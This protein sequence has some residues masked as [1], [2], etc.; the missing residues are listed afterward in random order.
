MSLHHSTVIV[1]DE[2]E[3]GQ[4]LMVRSPD[5]QQITYAVVP[6]GSRPGDSF[7]VQFPEYNPDDIV[8]DAEAATSAGCMPD[9]ERLLVPQPE[10]VEVTAVYDENPRGVDP[11]EGREGHD[12]HA[13]KADERE[14]TAEE[15]SFGN[16][17]DKFMEAVDDETAF[18]D[19]KAKESVGTTAAAPSRSTDLTTSGIQKKDTRE[20]EL[21]EQKFLL[22]HVPPGLPTGAM[23]QVE[24]PGENR[25]I[26]A[27]VPEGAR[28]F[29]MCYTPH[30]YVQAD[31]KITH[32]SPSTPPSSPSP[33]TPPSS[34][35][36]P[37]QP[38][39][40]ALMKKRSDGGPNVVNEVGKQKLLLVR[41]PP[42]TI[43]GTTVHVSVPDEP[44]RILAAVVPSGDVREFHVSYEAKVKADPPS[45][46]SFLPPASPYRNWSMGDDQL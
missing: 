41:V 29:H 46:R 44:G 24:I 16:L 10:Y 17:L 20:E 40:E 30:K 37:R 33:T 6:A 3:P 42:G 9:W 15:K 31:A 8:I 35:P 14:G 12:P 22:V 7:S 27:T 13:S 26:A 39:P 1:P 21:P 36:P 32:P 28:S 5:G 11:V 2:A 25:T 23:I 18:T 4:T 43:A 34:P 38:R 19:I 45:F